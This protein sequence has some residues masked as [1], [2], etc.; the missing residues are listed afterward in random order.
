MVRESGRALSLVPSYRVAE[1][2]E[3][4]FEEA[5]IPTLS[6]SDIEESKDAFTSQETCVAVL[7]NRYDGIDLVGDEC[8]LLIIEGL[9]KASNLQELFLLS[10]MACGTLLHDRIRTRIIQAVGRA[11]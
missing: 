6:A 9:P 3:K 8:R 11:C 7:A 2:H 5:D 10:R 4:L 1:R